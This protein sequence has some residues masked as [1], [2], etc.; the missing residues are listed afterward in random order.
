MLKVE[1]E[2]IYARKC[3]I[4]EISIIDKNEFLN[5]YH[6]QGE[7]KSK[8]KL[9]LFYANEL[10]LRYIIAHFLLIYTKKLILCFFHL[11]VYHT[12]IYIVIFF[13][14]FFIIKKNEVTY[15]IY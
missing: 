11:K 13:L 7:D 2:H 3:I 1:Q 12:F 8:V 10:V 4:K 5:K 6:I 9:G 14:I 15:E